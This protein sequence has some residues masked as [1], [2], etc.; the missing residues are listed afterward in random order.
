MT[1]QFHRTRIAGAVAGLVLALGA[2]H[3]FG[4]AFALQENSG[5]GLGNAY[6]G[7]AA[8]AEDAGTVWTNVAGMSKI[9]TNQ[10][11]AAINFIGP[12][13]KLNNNGSVAAFN[14]PLG[15]D[16]GDA[17]NWAAVPNMYLVV[18]INKE[19]T[20]GLGLNAPFGLVTEYDDGWLGRYQALKSDVKTM[21]INPALSWKINDS[22]AVG[23]G[24]NY[25]QIKATFTKNVNYSAA[26][27]QAA[28]QAAAGGLI[29]PATVPAIIASTG[30]LD[31]NANITGDDY[32]WGWNV[33]V[34]WD[35]SKDTRIGAQWRSSIKYNVTG[36]VD[37]SYPA[38]PSTVPPAL[39]P[40]VGLLAANVNQ[41]LASGG[42]TASIE[43][44]AIA[45]VSLFSRLNDKWDVMGDVQ[46]TGWSSL[47]ELKFV[48]TTGAVLSNTPE[49][50]KDA[51]RVSIGT[52]Y[53]MDDKWMFRGG[54]AWDQ[55][56]VNA[57]D[58]TPR[59]PDNDRT[60][61][62]LGAQ[63]KYSPALKFDAGFA[64]IF[65]KDPSINQADGNAA[66]NG[67][68]KGTSSNSV[69]ILSAQ[70]TYSF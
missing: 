26:L 40:V 56:P 10:V 27:A 13:A 67:L 19:W 14:Q 2:G 25:Q 47:P 45:N 43:V 6:A 17:G 37:F 53:R 49:N 54:L 9:G 29:P 36:N 8:A 62:T 5:S 21:N 15:G 12:S 46:F 41:V 23:A 31:A 34:L 1:T 51:W 3:A 44:P 68:I 52:N 30:G 32:A 64:Y 65:V 20:F 35:I 4:A 66:A 69:T 38:I 55:S 48:R 70:A 60:W 61:V 39:A 7:G 50:F 24:A 58:L 28:G 57:Q 63:Y 16:G 11:V 33:G 22:F 59:L 42:V 18:P